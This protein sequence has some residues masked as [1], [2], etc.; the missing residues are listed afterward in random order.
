MNELICVSTM[1]SMEIAEVTGKEHFIIM[2]DIRDELQKLKEGGVDGAY[3]FVLSSYTTNQNKVMPCYSLTKEGVLQLAARYDAV[4]RAKLIDLA[5]KHD[6]PVS[7]LAALQQT[8]A[9]LTEQAQRMDKIEAVQQT[10]ANTQQVIKDAVIAEPDNW[11]K[12]IYHKMNK[13][14]EAIGEDKYR[15]VRS[16]SYKLLEQ[17][18]GVLLDRRL[19][20]K[21]TRMLTEGASKTAINGVHKIDIIDEDKKLREIYGKIVSEYLI[22]YVA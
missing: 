20:N 5:M 12:D 2:R 3:K 19:L 7:A 10:M 8:V 17:R 9:A 11:R 16:E 14:A 15:E 1:T 21:Q 22:K 6:K 18:A 4:T 13:I